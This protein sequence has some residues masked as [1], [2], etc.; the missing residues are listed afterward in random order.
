[1]RA[2]KV[3]N[4]HGEVRDYLRAVGWGVFDSHDLGR[5]FADLVCARRGFTALVEVKGEKR[6]LR[7]GQEQ[8]SRWWPGVYIKAVS[9]ED[10]E[11]QLLQAETNL[12][13]RGARLGN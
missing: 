2:K 4:N 10:A 11:R 8:F 9:G 5:D 12:F 3:D 6:K 13:L 1:M 7:P